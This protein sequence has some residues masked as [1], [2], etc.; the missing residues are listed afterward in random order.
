[1]TLVETQLVK[2]KPLLQKQREGHISH[3]MATC[4]L[5]TRQ[6]LK[7]HVNMDKPL[8]VNYV[9]DVIMGT[10]KTK[11]GKHHVKS[12]QVERHLIPQHWYTNV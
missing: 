3:K 9:Y 6:H 12:A 10:I 4:T 1:M 11:K 8:V 5:M 7:N 2:W